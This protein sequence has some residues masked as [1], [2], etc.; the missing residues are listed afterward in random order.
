MTDKPKP[1]SD[2]FKEAARDLECDEDEKAWEDR[3]RKVAS[4][5]PAPEKSSG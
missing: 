4:Q 1:Q 3:L 2:K 5:K